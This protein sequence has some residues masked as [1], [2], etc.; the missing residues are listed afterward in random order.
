M[1]DFIH[2]HFYCIHGYNGLDTF[3]SVLIGGLG[4]VIF[5]FILNPTFCV[6]ATVKANNGDAW[7][8]PIVPELVEEQ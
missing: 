8:Y 3:Y 7:K 4:M 6:W 5:F 2:N 1:A